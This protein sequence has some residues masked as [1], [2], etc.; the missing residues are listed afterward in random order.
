MQ[1]INQVMT[2]DIVIA[3]PEQTIGDAARMMA[4]A[5]IGSLP[6]GDDD[7]LVGML[8]D[9]DIVIRAVARGMPADTPV[10]EVMTAEIRYCYD[11]QDVAEVARNMAELGVRRL[12]VVN[13]DKRI[14]GFVA[15]SN[16]AQADSDGAKET[17]LRGVATP[18]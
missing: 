2:P 15:L 3:C 4:K 18:H 8:T 6:V 5:D 1:T 14:V 16:I 13:R 17:L 12:P 9:R 10:R 7:R 11:D